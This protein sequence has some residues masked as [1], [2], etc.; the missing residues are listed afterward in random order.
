M[1]DWSRRLVVAG[2]LALSAASPAC[3]PEG[4][5]DAAKLPAEFP[6]VVIA[7]PAARVVSSA[8]DKG[9]NGKPERKVE[10]TTKDDI[11]KVRA[12]YAP[13]KLSGLEHKS[14]D[15]SPGRPMV[16]HDGKRFIDVKI[17]IWPG[18]DGTN[19]GLVANLM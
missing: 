7:Y 6:S 9:I 13:A 2:A 4:G 16:L 19:V 18:G 17:T 11:D 1:R 8:L 15:G 10:L 12:F 5:A 14:G 3:K